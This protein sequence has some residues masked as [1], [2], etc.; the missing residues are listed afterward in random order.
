MQQTVFVKGMVCQ[1]CIKTITTELEKINLQPEEVMLGEL[2]FSSDK[3]NVDLKLLN[4]KIQPLGFSI[5]ENKKEKDASIVKKMIHE[6]YNGEFDFPEGFLFSVY[7]SKFMGKS[8]DAI[9][10]SF[11]SEEGTT[12]EKYL[13]AYRIEKAKELL[14][15]TE[16][17]LTEVS[18]K[19]GFSSTAHISRQFKQYTGM[20]PSEFKMMHAARIK[21]N[22]SL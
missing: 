18:F 8:Y 2:R 19:L 16:Y 11:S 13:I 5:L 12:I 3:L 10:H 15:Y 1:R 9:S 21:I 7:L 17:T 22:S 14:L 4:D 6:V 20:T